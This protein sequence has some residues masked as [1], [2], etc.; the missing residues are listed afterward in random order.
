MLAS[1]RPAYLQTPVT[2]LQL[3]I[4]HDRE[5]ILPGL[6]LSALFTYGEHFPLEAKRAAER[7]LNCRIFELYGSS[8]CGFIASSCG[9]CDGFHVHAEIALTEVL[10]ED[11]SPAQPGEIG[12]L[13]VTPFYN[14]VMPLIRYD[15]ADFVQPS[16]ADGCDISLPKFDAIL[17]KKREPFVFPGGLVVRPYL[18]SDLVSD[19]LGAQIYQVAQVGPD[20]CEFRL[21][22]GTLRPE[23]MQFGEMTRRMRSL[24]WAG[25]QVDYRI[26]DAL[27]RRTIRSKIQHFVQEMPAAAIKELE[28]LA[29]LDLRDAMGDPA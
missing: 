5:R 7:Y 11:G 3:M 13:L 2:T 28:R 22:A 9:H 25:L 21:V 17:G 8:E 29:Q 26:V 19:C 23:Q 18:P 12:R 1:L 16:A 27:P 6:G 24:W 10:A 14:Y 20:R 15:H 4:A